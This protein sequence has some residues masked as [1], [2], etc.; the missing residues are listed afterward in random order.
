MTRKRA[1]ARYRRR[2]GKY[3]ASSARVRLSSS[4]SVRRRRVISRHC[5][6]G[7]GRMSTKNALLGEDG[8]TIAQSG[9]GE[10]RDSSEPHGRGGEA[11]S[12]RLEEFAQENGRVGEENLNSNALG[13]RP[14]TIPVTLFHMI[15]DCSESCMVPK[16]LVRESIWPL[17]ARRR[18]D[19]WAAALLRRWRP[20]PKVKRSATSTSICATF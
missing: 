12:A 14:V 6:G 5:G 11:S 13:P 9:K 4:A 17:R 20:F 16:V 1:A 15:V 19:T 10:H 8:R 2:R 7:A 18:A 3:F